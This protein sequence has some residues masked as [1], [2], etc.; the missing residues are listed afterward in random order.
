MSAPAV[1]AAL[2]THH[3]LLGVTAGVA[4]APPPLLG[5]P[6]VFLPTISA[7]STFKID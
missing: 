7:Q 2:W 1:P 6:L 3:Y 4:A 5:P